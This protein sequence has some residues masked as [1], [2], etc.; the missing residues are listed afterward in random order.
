MTNTMLLYKDVTALSRDLHR[1]LRLKPTDRF[2]HAAA[3]HWVPLGGVEF[4]RA[5]LYYP[6]VFVQEKDK[7][8]PVALL[9][10]QPGHNGYLD[11]EGKWRE[12]A[13]IPAFVRRYPFVLADTGAKNGELTVCIDRTWAG[14]NESE[15]Q[16]LFTPEGKNT[17]F[18]DEM[19]KFM[20]SF[21]VEMQRTADFMETI[22][23][24]G[25]LVQRT[26]TI[27]GAEGQALQLKDIHMIDEQKLGA[28]KAQD[29]YKLNQSGTLGWIFAHLMSLANLPP[30]LSGASQ[31]GEDASK[32][33]PQGKKQKSTQ[34]A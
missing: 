23:R 33:A 21:R 32:P 8:A 15:G 16:Q 30:L 31:A 26:L 10:L 20:D 19:M 5:A 4:F 25:L 13:Y 14:W 7:F 28:L 3:T 29:L 22:A 2:G 34:P 11:K 27:R 1:S 9:S 12:H 18:L 17:P 24:L 6:I